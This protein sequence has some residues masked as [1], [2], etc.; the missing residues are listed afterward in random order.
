MYPLKFIT[1][2]LDCLSLSVLNTE[3]NDTAINRREIPM[4]AET[5]G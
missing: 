3:I 4:D 1:V 2:L 5:I